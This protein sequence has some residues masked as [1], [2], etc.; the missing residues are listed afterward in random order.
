MHL[1]V[2]TYL[3]VL[4]LS[5]AV[6]ISASHFPGKDMGPAGPAFYPQLVAVVLFALAAWS[7]IRVWRNTTPL[8]RVNVPSRVLAGMAISLGYIG[9]MYLIGY[10]PSTFLY[11]L[12]IMTLIRGGASIRRLLFDSAIL[13]AVA[14]GI[15]ET[16]VATYLPQGILF[17]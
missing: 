7:L 14:Y 16:I 1:L 2:V 12:A 17:Q 6:F 11:V 5:V 3:G 4:L 8:K 10:F 13:T 9:V 15:F